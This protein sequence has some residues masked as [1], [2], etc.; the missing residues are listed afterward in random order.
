MTDVLTAGSE[1]AETLLRLA[2]SAEKGSEHPLG[3]A[4]VAG[5]EARGLELPEAEHFDS[6]TGR[7]IEAVIESRIVLAGNR[8]LMDERNVSLSEMESRPCMWR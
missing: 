1:S 4:I 3:Q 2:A 5:A 8:K 6:L 7:G